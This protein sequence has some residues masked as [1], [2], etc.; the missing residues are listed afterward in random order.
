MPEPQ[1]NPEEELVSGI[2]AAARGRDRAVQVR[3][4]A[5]RTGI[6]ER[7]VR[8]IVKDLVE[9]HHLPIGSTSGHPGGYYTITDQAEL[10]AVRCS[11]IRRAVSILNRAKVYD[12]AGWV[13]E[14]AGQLALKFKQEEEKDGRDIDGR[15]G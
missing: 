5:R 6:D 9:R 12:K 10:R 4:I 13:S 11:L 15:A 2:I 1:L 7:R 14:M 3:E 8:D